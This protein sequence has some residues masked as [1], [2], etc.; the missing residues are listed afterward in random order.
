MMGSRYSGLTSQT[1]AMFGLD[2]RIALAIFSALIVI[3]GYVGFGRVQTARDAALA[4]DIDALEIALNH[5]QADTGTF[6][7]FT[8]EKPYD[9]ADTSEDITALWNKNKVKQGF[10]ANWNG[11]YVHRTSRAR[12]PYGAFSV[13][14]A[15]QDRTNECTAESQCYI[16]LKLT[17][18]PEKTWSTLNA[19]YDEAGGKAPEASGGQT[20]LGKVQAD[21]TT[22]VRTLYVRTSA[23][24]PG[25]FGNSQNGN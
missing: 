9:D 16:W 13:F 24:R 12:P 20:T 8:L 21:A 25:I 5:Y 14:Y 7:M 2:A 19:Y 23:A 18:V 22:T 17:Q 1:G 10:Q 6:Y 3:V 11:P 4:A 15:Q